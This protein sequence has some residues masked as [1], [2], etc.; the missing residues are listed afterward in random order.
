MKL[1][2]SIYVGSY[3]ITLKIFEISK[4]KGLKE[5]DFMSTSLDLISDI[6]K[7]G[8]LSLDTINRLCKILK[9]MKKN[10]DAYKVDE[11][12]LCANNMLFDADNYPIVVEQIK[13]KTGMKAEILSNSERRFL[14]YL[15][16]ASIEDFEKIIDET[17]VLVDVGGASLQFTLFEKGEVITT[18]HILLGSVSLL[19]KMKKLEFVINADNKM[20]EYVDKEIDSFKKMYLKD[21]NVTNM[22]ILGDIFVGNAIVELSDKREMSG[23]KYADYLESVDTNLIASSG[24]VV[25]SDN[26]ELIK[27]YVIIHKSIS[28]TINPNVVHIPSLSVNEGIVLQSAYKHKWLESTHDFDA[29][30][31]SAALNIS[32]RYKSFQP[33]LLAL[34]KLSDMMFDAMKKYH[35]MT[36]RDRLLMEVVCLLHDCGKYISI[37]SA[38]DCSHQIIMATEILGLTHKERELIATVVYYNRYEIESFEELSDSFTSEEYIKICKLLAILKVAN[39]LDRS[40]KQKMK[41]VNMKVKD[42]ELVISIESTLSYDLE[43]SMFAEKAE[44]FESVFAIRP[45]IK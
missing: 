13:L 37:A 33:H 9:D 18:Q 29:D 15:A 21:M 10:M 23:K 5:V 3:E 19:D 20:L 27:P 39:A 42:E 11:Y 40:H 7:Y 4:N 6:N 44:F 22:I 17:T 45:V 31:I 38:A 12:R 32:E 1:F 8:K 25:F 30:V 35:G 41:N 2:G 36:E 14:S 16:T 28:R 34:K 26:E 43:R 24:Y